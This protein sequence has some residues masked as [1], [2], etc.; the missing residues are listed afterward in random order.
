MKIEFVIHCFIGFCLVYDSWSKYPNGLLAGTSHH[1]GVYEECISV[2]GPVQGKYC[3]TAIKLT[4]AAGTSFE[5]T[6][7]DKP[8]DLDHAWNEMLGVSTVL[9]VN[10]KNALEALNRVIKTG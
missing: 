9:L 10:V 6:K 8:E 4:A 3:M 7:R 1:M 2:H 5:L